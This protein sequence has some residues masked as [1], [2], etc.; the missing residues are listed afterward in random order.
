MITYCQTKKIDPDALERLFLSLDWESGRYK[1]RLSQ[2]LANY[3]YVMTAWDDNRL[4]GLIGAMDDG[5]MTAYVHY[6][7]VD[8]SYQKHGIG[9]N[10]VAELK[11]HYQSYLKICLCAV[12]TYV[13][14]YEHQGFVVDATETA[15]AISRFA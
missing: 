13:P 4:V 1:E 15:M 5:N 11:N 6:L 10:L 8:P 7:C 14:F 3:G 12:N 2:A 9:K